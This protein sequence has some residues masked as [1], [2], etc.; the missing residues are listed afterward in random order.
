MALAKHYEEILLRRREHGARIV[1]EFV[2][3]QETAD[4]FDP[5]PEKFDVR[6]F[7]Q[8]VERENNERLARETTVVFR[9]NKDRTWF[10]VVGHLTK[11]EAAEVAS[12]MPAELL[13]LDP[14]YGGMHIFNDHLFISDD[15]FSSAI[16]RWGSDITPGDLMQRLASEYEFPPRRPQMAE[17]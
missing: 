7:I 5:T 15:L 8:R 6:A 4:R 9:L 16:Q 11:G 1:D 13:D 2:Y 12:V 17:A 3:P 14:L 10:W